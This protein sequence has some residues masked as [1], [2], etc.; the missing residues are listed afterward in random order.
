MIN[1]DDA[2]GN[3]KATYDTLQEMFQMVPKLFVSQSIR[4]DLLEPIVLYIKRLMV[5]TH[6]LSRS[7]K[8]LI[9]AYVSKI[10]VCAYWVDAHSA[11]VMTQGFTQDQVKSILED[12]DGSSL[13]DDKT[14]QI[15]HFSE[16]VTRHAYKVTESDIKALQ[17]IGC[18]EEEVFEAVAVTSLFNYMDRMA[19]ALGAPVENFQEMVTSM[20]QS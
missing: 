2:T 16:K 3:L 20:M 6:G 12:I 17:D 7:T 14:K 19:D 18:T 13:I 1:P 4:P 11:M 8:E 9:A 10:N 15:L 5:E